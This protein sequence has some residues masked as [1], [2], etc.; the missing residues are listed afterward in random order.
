MTQRRKDD[1]VAVRVTDERNPIARPALELIRDAIGDVQPIAD[2]LSELEEDRRDLPTGGDYHLVVYPDGE[3]TPLAAAAGI[4]L[5]AV[6]AGFVSYLAVRP[7]QR[8][9]RLGRRLRA[10]LVESFRDD[11][12]RLRG[13]E[14]AWTVG[15]VRRNSP[16]LRTLVRDGRA[17]PFDVPYFHPWMPLSAKGRYVLYREP[18][19]DS[20]RELP[21]HEV[22]RLLFTIWRRA[23]RIRY[24]LQSEVF[25]FMVDDLAER[26]MVGADP[27]FA[28]APPARRHP[29]RE[30]TSLAGPQGEPPA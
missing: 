13:E 23:Y 12:R 5:Q 21:A 30:A 10:W 26:E 9:R 24:P 16:W 22:E 15:E 14:L 29:R 4:Y 2:L 1:L 3:G 8:R 18:V 19:A 6:N 27:T 17:I 20:R 25:R 11:A 28:P 7:D